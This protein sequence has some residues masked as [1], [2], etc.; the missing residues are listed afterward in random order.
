MRWTKK[1]SKKTFGERH[2]Q[3][4]LPRPIATKGRKHLIPLK[5]YF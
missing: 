1:L 2:V 4:H 5:R 3:P